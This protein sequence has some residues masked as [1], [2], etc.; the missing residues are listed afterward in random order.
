MGEDDGIRNA[1]QHIPAVREYHR[2]VVD[3]HDPG[4]AIGPPRHVVHVTRGRQAGTNIDKLADT[5]V[6]SQKIHRSPQKGPVRPARLANVRQIGHY[7]IAGLPVS[8]VIVF[9]AEQVVINAGRT[10]NIGP[11]CR[12]PVTAAL[13]I[14][15][16]RQR[17]VSFRALREPELAVPGADPPTTGLPPPPTAAAV[18]GS[19]AGRPKSRHNSTQS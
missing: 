12:P 2:I 6:G 11:E 19:G 7:F 10:W 9:A 1:V 18:A 5:G 4:L 3:V 16:P 13:A 8:R 14:L 17:R 15:T